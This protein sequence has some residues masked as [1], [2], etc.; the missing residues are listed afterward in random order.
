MDVF[1]RI[2]INLAAFIMLGIV[3]YVAYKR[4]DRQDALNRMF[5]YTS[6]AILVELLFEAATCVIN[7]RPELWLIP[8]TNILHACLFATGS[9]LTYLWYS[10]L[11]RWICPG[12]I[13]SNWKEQMMRA[14]VLVNAV[15]AITS[16]FSHY[17]FYITSDNV[18]HRGPLFNFA[19]F[20]IYIYILLGMMT[21]L[22]HR[23]KV[24][25]E[26]F[27]PLF[28]FGILPLIGGLVQ[29]LFYGILLMWST[30]AF[31]LVIVYNFIKERMVQ[32]DGLTGAWTRL[33]FDYYIKQLEEK[34]SLDG[35]GA[36]FI[37]IDGLK[38]INDQYG[39][40]EGDFVLKTSVKLIKA[41]LRKTDVVGRFGG[42]EFV[43]IFHDV[44]RT[45]M[46][47][48]IKRIHKNFYEYSLTADKKYDFGCSIGGDFY[49]ANNDTATGFIHR[50]DQIMYANK[51][52]KK[53]N[54]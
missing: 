22:K 34:G 45:Y 15:L 4:L 29:S 14:L 37:D 41:A 23:S 18:Y 3:C 6:V 30:T 47:L 27:V 49:D 9:L 8:L 2:D 11:R 20:S 31:S 32:L 42:D 13:F 50:I 54:D 12:V 44:D 43:V 36:L 7:G 35:V 5:L 10:F 26:E 51:Q 17:I 21:L 46:D 19:G 53:E 40:L 25:R 39:H 38:Q 16:P 48:I 52:S 24:V 1:L 33:S 28:I